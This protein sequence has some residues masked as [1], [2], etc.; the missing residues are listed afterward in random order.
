MVISFANKDKTWKIVVER[1]G[2]VIDYYR[3]KDGAINDISRLEKVY[4]DKLIV[5][6]HYGE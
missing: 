1:T 2:E 5:I 3:T 6:R 4:M